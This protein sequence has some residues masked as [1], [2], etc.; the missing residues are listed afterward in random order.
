MFVI[1]VMLY[2]FCGAKFRTVATANEA[3]LELEKRYL[4]TNC[5]EIGKFHHPSTLDVVLRIPFWDE[6]LLCEV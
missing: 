1:H 4:S 3:K 2:S 6:L 5:M